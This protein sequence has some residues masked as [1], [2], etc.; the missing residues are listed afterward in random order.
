MGAS[1]K[2]EF[3]L[4]GYLDELVEDLHK[5]VNKALRAF[6]A[7][8]IHDARVATRRLKAAMGLLESV[9]SAEHRK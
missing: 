1:D 7:E 9:L 8:A 6:D 5:N 4:L 3:P 2:T